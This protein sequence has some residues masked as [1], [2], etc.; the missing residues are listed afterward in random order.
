ME[1]KI[2]VRH[3]PQVAFTHR[4]KN[5]HGGDGVRQKMLELHTIVVAERPHEAAWGRTEVVM[6]KFGKGDHIPLR[7]PRLQVVCHRRDPLRPRRGNAGAQKSL[8]L[9]VQQA[10]VRHRRRA[11]VI[12]S[13]EPHRHF[14]GRR[15][16]APLLSA[17][18]RAH[19]G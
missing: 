8:L 15:K 1:P 2:P 19:V 16:V 5:H 7:R 18:G 3:H 17:R 4:G 13:D 11:P 9:E 12:G 14:D 6:M 10:A